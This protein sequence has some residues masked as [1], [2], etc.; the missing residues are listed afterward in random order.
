MSIVTM[1]VFVSLMLV[2]GSL[3][4]FLHS[5]RQRDFDHADRL[6]LAPLD[7]D[8]SAA[9]PAAAETPATT[10]DSCKPDR[11]NTTTP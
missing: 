11:S 1:Q 8:A 10:K 3:V 2:A 7:D 4:L 9:T 5:V 6:S